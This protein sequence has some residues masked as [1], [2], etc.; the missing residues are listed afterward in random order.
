LI[1]KFCVIKK[2]LKI[3]NSITDKIIE[4]SNEQKTKLKKNK[5]H[6]KKK[7]LTRFTIN[8]F[9][10]LEIASTL[11]YQK[12]MS[13]YE[14]KPAPSQPKKTCIKLSPETNSNINNVKNEI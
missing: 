11:V 9:T 6:K 5:E 2:E 1:K 13:K 12:L 7:S 14:H 4:K 3:N 10:P 8:A